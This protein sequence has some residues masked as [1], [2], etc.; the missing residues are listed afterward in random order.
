M[1][2]IND[3]SSDNCIMAKPVSSPDMAQ[4]MLL[5]DFFRN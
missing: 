3:I 5:L 4:G 1:K 2:E